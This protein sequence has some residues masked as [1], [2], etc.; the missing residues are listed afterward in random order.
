M[1]RVRFR[2]PAERKLASVI[3][4][5]KSWKDFAGEWVELP[6]DIGKAEVHAR[7]E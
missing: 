3:V 2:E 5:G 7:F 4:N 1:L 6:G